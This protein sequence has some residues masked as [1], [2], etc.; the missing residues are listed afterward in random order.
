M[1]VMNAPQVV[2]EPKFNNKYTKKRLTEINVDNQKIM[3]A[4]D[5]INSKGTKLKGKK[6]TNSIYRTP[7]VNY[8]PK[9]VEN[10]NTICKEN[11]VR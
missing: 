6:I 4:I 1:K 7:A 8:L 3:A 5:T 10:C 9:K 2:V 11:E